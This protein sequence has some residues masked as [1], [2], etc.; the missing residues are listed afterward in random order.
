MLDR[1]R[2]WRPPA[3]QTDPSWRRSFGD[4][5]RP[6]VPRY[7]RRGIVERLL[8]DGSVLRAARRGRRRATQL[9]VL[10]RCNVEG[11]AICLINAY[12]NDAHERRLRE[13]AHEVLGADVPVSISSETSPLAKEYARASDDGDRRLHEA[14]LHPLRARARHRPARRRLR[15]ARSTS[16]TARRRCCRGRRRSRSRS[17]SSSPG[18]PRG[19]CRARALGAAIGE[20]NL[21]CADVGGTSTDI[22]LVVDGQPFV[23]NT[24]ELEHD[25]VINALST[26]ISS[27]GAGGGSI[28]SISPTGDVLVGPGSAGSEPGPGLLRP[29]RHAADDDRRLPAD[30]D[31]R[32]RRLRRRR[33]PPRP[34]RRPARVRVARHATW[35]ST[36]ASPTRSASRSRTS[37][38]RSRTSRSATASTRAT[39]RSIAYGAAGPMLLPGGARADARRAHRDLPPHPGNFSALG[40]LSSDLVYYDSRSAYVMLTPDAGAADR[41]GLRGDGARSCASASGTPPG[42]GH[43]PAQLRR[44]PVRPELG[45]AV[46]RGARRADRRRPTWSSASTPRTSAATATASPTCRSR[47]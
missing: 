40:L 14:D 8:A 23:N 28:V 46:R 30:G 12:V 1:G 38:R 42:D 9:G 32:P 15:P 11:V 33:D 5:A 16:P 37:P 29:R 34:G 20:R 4:V 45:D 25:L 26:E 6:L 10:A 47:A 39:S 17:G 18:P 27:V 36:S 41:R 2:I 3:S 43:G 24:F 44:P 21:I 7:L 22:S 31:P 19:R 35:A 13:L